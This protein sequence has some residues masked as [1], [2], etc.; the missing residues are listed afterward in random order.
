MRL[1]GLFLELLVLYMFSLNWLMKG[2]F[3]LSCNVVFDLFI[4][5]YLLRLLVLVFFFMFNFVIEYLKLRFDDLF[6]GKLK[7]IL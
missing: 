4:I 2:K 3:I 6:F 1:N 7:L 5:M